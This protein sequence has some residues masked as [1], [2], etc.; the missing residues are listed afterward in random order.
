MPPAPIVGADPRQ[1]GLDRR[2]VRR[3]PANMMHPHYACGIYQ[4]IAAALVDIPFRFFRKPASRNFLQ[5][6]PP[7]ANSPNFP[8]ACIQHTICAVYLPCLI[9]QKRP[10]Q[11][12]IFRIGSGKKPGLEGDHH[13][14]DILL[15]E[16]AFVLLQPQQ[17]SPARQ[18][19]QVAMKNHQ[20]PL[21]SEIV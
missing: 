12:G 11:P 17:V 4:H 8:E 18:S 13:H 19:P 20:Q 3:P 7:G 14:F 6:S 2:P 21:T 10:V 15:P 16:L 9:D 1:Y 5:V